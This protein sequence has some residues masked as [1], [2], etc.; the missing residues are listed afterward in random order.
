MANALCPVSGKRGKP[1]PLVTLRSLVLR[2]HAAVVEDRAWYFCDR[3]DCEV[4]YFTDDGRTLEK[5]AL[6]VRVGL[7][8]KEAPRPICYCFDHTAES[9]RQEIEKTGRSTVVASIRTKV[10]AGECSCEVLNPR[11]TCCLGDVNKEVKAALASVQGTDS[12]QEE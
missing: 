8:E 10:E 9:I 12:A 1:V 4:V 7:K 5:N 6:T 2:E 11:G 3:L